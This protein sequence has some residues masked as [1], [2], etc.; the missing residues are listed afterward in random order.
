VTQ[1]TMNANNADISE[2][3]QRELALGDLK[4]SAQHE[5]AAGVLKQSAQDL[6]R[7]HNATS[8]IERELYFDAHRWV[9]SDDYS[10]PFSFPNVCQILNREPEELRQELVG[11]LAFGHFGQWTRRCSRAIRRFLESLTERFATE[12][13]PGPALP[14]RLAQTWH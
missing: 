2:E 6:R 12:Y 10:W 7:F 11:D 9:M 14:A 1:Q 13:N 8:R 3:S 4:Q 5:L